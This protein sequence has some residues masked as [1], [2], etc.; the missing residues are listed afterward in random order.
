MIYVSIGCF[1]FALVLVFRSVFGYE[2]LKADNMWDRGL[3]ALLW[4]NIAFDFLKDITNY[5]GS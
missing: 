4:T 3:L 1:V 5:M 2:E